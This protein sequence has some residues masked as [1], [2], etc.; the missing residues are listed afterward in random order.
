MTFSFLHNLI[1]S[2]SNYVLF[3]YA[4]FCFVARY[5]QLSICSENCQNSVRVPSEMRSLG[6]DKYY[7]IYMYMTI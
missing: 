3:R 5:F 7:I 4:D 1:S 2:E 6:E